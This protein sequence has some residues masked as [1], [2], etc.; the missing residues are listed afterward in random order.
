M[1]RNAKPNALATY[2]QQTSLVNYFSQPKYQ[3]LPKIAFATN[4]PFKKDL[5]QKKFGDQISK[6]I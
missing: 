1:D 5:S 4:H 6:Q 3:D 2:H